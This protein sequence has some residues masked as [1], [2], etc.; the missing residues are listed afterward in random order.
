[1]KGFMGYERPD[2]SVGI[3]NHVAVMSTIACANGVV[4]RICS[5]VPETIRIIHV[6]GCGRGGEDLILHT[7][8]LQNLVR[9][10]NYA[11]VLIVGLGCEL[12]PADSLYFAAAFAH[13]PSERL[14]IQ[15]EGGSEKTALKGIEIAKK[16]LKK[17]NEVK[18]QLFPFSRLNIGLKCGGSDA[19]SGLTANPAIGVASDWIVKEGGQSILTEIEELKGTNHILKRRAANEEIANRIDEVIKQTNREAKELLGELVKLT[20]TAGNIEGGMTTILEKSL[21]S[22]V[23]GGTSPINQVIESAEIPT[24]NG[25]V[26]MNSSSYDPEAMTALAAA[27]CQIILFSTGRGT[28]LG[29]PGLPVVKISSN[30]RLFQNF[31]SD[32]DINAGDILEGKQTIEEV[33]IELIDFIKKVADGEQTKAEINKQS[34]VLCM[35]TRNRSL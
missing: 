4:E 22:A 32:I 8:T 33:G 1:M 5:E 24:E 13:K 6:N 18:P 12:I 14:V 35:Y 34:G 15:E 7:R 25:L 27:G 20:I 26:L 3:R 28:P 17:A 19:F 2:G 29:F 10:P 9:N 16:L 23:K 21:G 31:E 30:N 11:A